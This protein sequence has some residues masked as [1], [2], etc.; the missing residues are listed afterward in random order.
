M[1]GRKL[2]KNDSPGDFGDLWGHVRVDAKERSKTSRQRGEGAGV[3][4]QRKTH[5]RQSLVGFSVIILTQE[6]R[7][8]HVDELVELLKER[9]GRLTDRDSL[10]SALAK[11]DHQGILVRRVA[12]GKFTVRS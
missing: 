2:W 11:K 12:P 8:V 6:Q 9:H 4:P 1:A 5:K 3:P 7:P 10:T